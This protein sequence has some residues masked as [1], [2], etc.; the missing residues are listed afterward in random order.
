[1]TYPDYSPYFPFETIRPEQRTA[2]EFIL[3]AFLNQKKRFVILNAGT[4][5]GKSVIAVAL[6]RYLEDHGGQ[7]FVKN[8]DGENDPVKGTYVLTTQK[9][10]QQQYIDDFGPSSGRD[11]MRSLKSASNYCCRF[12]A[13]LRCSDSRRLLKQLGKTADDTPFAKCCKKACPYVLDKQEFLEH[14]L[15]ITNFSYFLAETMY[16]KQLTPRAFLVIDEAHNTE[17]EL[18]KF[19]EVTFSER[20]AKTLGC[21]VPRLNTPSEVFE[22]VKGPYK[23]AVQ[24]LM[25]GLTKKMAE[26]FKSDSG[27]HTGLNDVGKRYEMLDKHV[28]KINRFIEVYNPDNWIMNYVRPDPNDHH[29]GRKFE[30]KPVDV[31]SYGES[32]LYRFGSRVLLMSAT[33]VDKDVFCKSVGIDPDEAAYLYLP[34]PFPVAN[35]PIHYLAVGSMSRANIESTLPKLA[36]VVGQLLDLHKDEKGMIHTVNYRIA[37]YLV[38]TLSSPRLLLHDSQNRD[39]MIDFHMK[40]PDAT[41]LISPSMTEGVDLVDD[42]S[43]FQILCKV[44]FPYLGDKVIQLRK[45]RNPSWYACQTVRSIIQAF[46]RSIRNDKDHAT[47]YILDADWECLLR[48]YRHMF[49]SEFLAALT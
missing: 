30:F 20:F 12:Y 28:C 10:L 1:M 16:A 40:C 17:N 45:Q 5:I 8:V 38:D 6:A 4:G 39:E 9:I 48:T 15:G 47:S 42:A 25:S 3:D 23:R 36:L 43:R 2:I 32:H 44:P 21:K 41:V 11:L 29:A 27:D 33:I 18:G 46:G 49:P 34:S 13:D 22:W 7:L 24:K 37:K 19:I 35:R 14:P 31:S 26:I